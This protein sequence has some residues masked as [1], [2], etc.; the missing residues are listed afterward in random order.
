MITMP[1]STHHEPAAPDAEALRAIERARVRALVQRNVAL[2]AQW[3]SPD[4][5]LVTPVGMTLTRD[6]YLGAIESGHLVYGAWDP[7]D[8]DVRLHDE[9]AALRYRSTMQVS[10][11][12]HR[13]PS[14]DYWHTDLYEQRQG[15]WQLVWS[16]A[17]TIQPAP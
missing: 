9:V 2:A 16:H 4:F 5:Q 12:T 17:T 6:Q 3:H 15:A 11:G 7:Q 13:V 14:A 8:I 10:L 1:T